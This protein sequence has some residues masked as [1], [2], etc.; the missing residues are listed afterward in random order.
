MPSLSLPI[1]LSFVFTMKSALLLSITL[2][3]VAQAALT[4]AQIKSVFPDA[5][6]LTG[7]TL[8]LAKAFDLQTVTGMTLNPIV[9]ISN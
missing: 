5:T 4:D 1:T 2:V 9:S 7:E 6:K 8:P 3:S